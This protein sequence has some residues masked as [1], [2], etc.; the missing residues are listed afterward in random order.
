MS[1]KPANPN[2]TLGEL[3]AELQLQ[4]FESLDYGAALMLAS[5]N[6]YY[7]ASVDPA[8]VP[9]ERKVAFLKEAE[10][11]KQHLHSDD[12]ESLIKARE[13][14][15][16][17]PF[18]D[19]GPGFACVECLRI[20]KWHAFLDYSMDSKLKKPRSLAQAKKY[21]PER[22]CDECG[23]KPQ[24]YSHGSDAYH[25]P[26]CSCVPEFDFW[27]C[28]VCHIN[29]RKDPIKHIRDICGCP[30]CGLCVHVLVGFDRDPVCPKCSG[31]LAY[32]TCWSWETGYVNGRRRPF[33]EG[34]D[35]MV[36]EEEDVVREEDVVQVYEEEAFEA[37][38][39]DEEKPEEEKYAEEEE[40]E[41][42]EDEEE[43]VWNF[44]E[45]VRMLGWDNDWVQTDQP[46][47]DWDHVQRY[48]DNTNTQ[49]W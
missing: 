18:A 29:A 30:R 41:E 10:F 45:A 46:S 16:E 21:I 34:K 15:P 24:V 14:S 37:E 43:S 38:E 12:L 3:P 40:E 19:T 28:K 33:K 1:T 23:M 49:E 17:G 6:K 39:S 8:L 42:E 35:G 4:I 26:A 31:I 13:A 47:G 22:L 9:L 5:T 7:R 27:W 48:W 44:E 25:H 20:K 36:N 11:F 2:G 32:E